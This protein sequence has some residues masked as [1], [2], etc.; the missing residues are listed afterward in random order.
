MLCIGI[1]WMMYANTGTR[2]EGE[3]SAYSLFNENFEAFVSQ[4]L[5][6]PIAMYLLM[7]NDH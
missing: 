1:L 6:L 4:L 7:V 2:K 5:R 3:K